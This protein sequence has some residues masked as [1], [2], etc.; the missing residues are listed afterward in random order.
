MV[1]EIEL[2]RELKKLSHQFDDWSEGKISS[3]E[4][5]R[6]IHQFHSGIAH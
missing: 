5:E 6:F 3:S 1:Y 2:S 4:L